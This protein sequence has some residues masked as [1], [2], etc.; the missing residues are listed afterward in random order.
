MTLLQRI[1]ESVKEAELIIQVSKY[2]NSGMLST[3]EVNSYLNE[4]KQG[5]DPF[6]Q[7]AVTQ[8]DVL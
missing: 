7:K 2:F 6:E 1:Q 5:F 8:E 4:I 3:S